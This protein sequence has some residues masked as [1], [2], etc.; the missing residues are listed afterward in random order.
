VFIVIGGIATGGPFLV[1]FL[2]I[3]FFSALLP[4]AYIYNSAEWVATEYPKSPSSP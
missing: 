1:G 4:F 3:L 2:I